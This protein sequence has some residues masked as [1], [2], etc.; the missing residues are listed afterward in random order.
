MGS[1]PQLGRGR[2]GI[3]GRGQG[4]LPQVSRA[5]LHRHGSV[6]PDARSD[7]WNARVPFAGEGRTVQLVSYERVRVARSAMHHTPE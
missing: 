6:R 5:E 1:S 4:L 2:Q 3:D 7:S